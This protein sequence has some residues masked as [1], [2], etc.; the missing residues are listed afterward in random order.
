MRTLSKDEL[1][2]MTIAFFVKTWEGAKGNPGELFVQNK[3]ENK[4]T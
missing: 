4:M 1:K 2:A 3:K